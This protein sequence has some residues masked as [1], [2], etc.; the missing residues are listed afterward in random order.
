MQKKSIL[1]KLIPVLLILGVL[2]S[3]FFVGKM[4]LQKAENNNLNFIPKNSLWYAQI[5]LQKLIKNE[6]E[7]LIF[8]DNDKEI[9]LL[10]EELIENKDSTLKS[11]Q[12]NGIQ[13]NSIVL[14]FGL[15]D[16]ITGILFNLTS[17]QKFN[18]SFST[19]PSRRIACKTKDNV[20]VLLFSK[21]TNTSTKEL[22]KKAND[23][24]NANFL[25][26]Q[27]SKHLIAINLLKKIKKNTA[28]EE[29]EFTIDINKNQ[30]LI[31]SQFE[32]SIESNTMPSLHPENLHIDWQQ[33]PSFISDSLRLWTHSTIPDLKSI[34]INYTGSDLVTEP[35]MKLAPIVNTVLQLND[36]LDFK[37][38]LGRIE[39]DQ[40]IESHTSE[41]FIYAGTSYFYKQTNYHT[42]YVGRDKFDPDKLTTEDALLSI[43]GSPESITNIVGKSLARKLLG[44][45]PLYKAS[46]KLSH[47][48]ENID[49][50]L[51]QNQNG[52][53]TL[54]SI[55]QFKE[56]KYATNELLKFILAIEN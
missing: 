3:F 17:S 27:K 23:F 47:S 26:I 31:D 20:G 33:I 21:D 46:D 54:H 12:Q 19:R 37:S 50:E 41:S 35:L 30:L 1:A 39:M 7:T 4:I 55:I 6:V 2:W 43:S 36:S 51:I 24:F 14:A 53:Y 16:G 38:F 9:L 44:I 18:A 34:S 56:S 42:I 15:N 45:L 11:I 8:S 5:D 29:G 32:S 48:V 22:K 52:K 49:V 40:L 28:I 13:I 25:E 10:L